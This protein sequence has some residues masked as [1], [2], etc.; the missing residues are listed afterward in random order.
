MKKAVLLLGLLI[1]ML[2]MHALAE[3]ICAGSIRSVTG[4]DNY[5]TYTWT[6]V[7]GCVIIGPSDQQDVTFQVTGAHGEICTLDYYAWR[8][9]PGGGS[10][11]SAGGEIFSIVACEVCAGS[12]GQTLSDRSLERPLAEDF[13]W[14]MIGAGANITSGA[15]EAV[16]TYTV[17]GDPGDV[18]QLRCIYSDGGRPGDYLSPE[19]T[20]I[21]CTDPTPQAIPTLS[22][23]GMIIFSLMLAVSAIWMIRRRQVS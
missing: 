19:I 10:S 3:G 12:E 6:V 15:D 14:S 22:E 5:D 23:W 9:D 2:P 13:S 8:A 1:F 4:P 11:S 21:D 20:V 16:V 18:F 17:T 7:S